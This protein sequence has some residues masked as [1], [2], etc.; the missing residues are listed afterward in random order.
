MKKSSTPGLPTAAF[1]IIFSDL[2]GTLLDSNTYRWEKALPALDLC[3]MLDIPVILVSSKTRG[4]IDLLR[5]KLSVK[6]PFVSENG[7]GIFFPKDIFKNPPT[8]AS[9]DDNLWKWSL[10][11]PYDSLVK[12]LQEIRDKLGWNIRGFSDMSIEEISRLTGLDRQASHLAA[13]REY[14][15]PF[16]IIDDKHQDKSILI[17][18]AAQRGLMV[19]VGGRFYHLQGKNDKGKAMKKLISWYKELKGGVVSVALGDTMN[20]F[21]MLELADYPV[22]IR[23]L[24]DFA[25]PK[26][27]ILRLKVTREIGPKGWNTAVFDILD[28]MERADNA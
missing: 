17:K 8:G 22:L 3:K 13:M 19:T 26:K 12:A 21:P 20:D 7:G 28:K 6:A 25:P 15:E 9:L 16:I 1:I 5:H 27:K 11:C 10:G 18:A 2:D 24:R 14:D 4:E 23:S